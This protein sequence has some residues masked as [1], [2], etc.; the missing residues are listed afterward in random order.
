MTWN[1][2][3]RIDI[4]YTHGYYGD[5]NPAN[6]QFCLAL[7]G[8]YAP[9]FGTACELGYGQGVSLNIHAAAETTVW[10]GTDF[11]PSQAAFASEMA[12][13]SG[14]HAHCFADAFQDFAKRDDLPEFDYIALHGIWSWISPENQRAIVDIIDKKLKIGGALYISYNTNPGW[15]AFIPTRNLL[16]LYARGEAGAGTVT[17]RMKKAFDF[18]E[19]LKDAN[20]AYFKNNPNAATRLDRFQNTAQRYVAHELFNEFWTPCLFSELAA[21]LTNARMT[22]AA[23]AV[24]LQNVPGLG[25]TE[26]QQKILSEISDPILAQTVYDF[27]INNQFRK[28]I[29]LKGPRKMSRIRAQEVLGQSRFILAVPVEKLT[30]KVNTTYGEVS[31]SPAIFE[32]F[33]TGLGDGKIHTIAELD[34]IAKSLATSEDPPEGLDKVSYISLAHNL[35]VLEAGGLAYSCQDKNERQHAATTAK[36]LNN[37]ILNSALESGD[38]TFMA[39]PVTGGGIA[40]SRLNQLF[41]LAMKKGAKNVQELTAQIQA[42][43][44]ATGQTLLKEGKP[45]EESEIPGYL[46]EQ[47]EGF[48]GKTLPVYRNLMLI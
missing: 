21:L 39:S 44:P 5:L 2:G 22:F 13:A 45:I 41:M 11:N 46:N 40:V 43:L 16:E 32:I 27:M 20:A 14:S 19:R 47:I 28:D 42:W 23:P 38:I 33:R 37:F 12:K 7:A 1:D 35:A 10:Y 48:L 34:K 3:Y 17:Q 29:W 30:E 15:A 4:T 26:E 25:L 24:P 8:L 18:V 6:I 36:N 9:E 31:F